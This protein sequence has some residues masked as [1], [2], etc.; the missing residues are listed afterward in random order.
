M[1]R[2]LLSVVSLALLASSTEGL[3][4]QEPERYHAPYYSG[5]YYSGDRYF[6]RERQPYGYRQGVSQRPGIRIERAGDTGGYLL[7][8]HTKGMSPE[9]IA[10]S[11]ERGRIR[12]ETATLSWRNSPNVRAST[13]GRFSRTLPL[14]RDADTG[15]MET[16]VTNGMLEIRIPKR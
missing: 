1:D 15:A 8:I 13:Y 4:W 3:A 10:V 12:L 16:R 9:D 7:R 6:Y 11:T 2:L 14:P 5:R